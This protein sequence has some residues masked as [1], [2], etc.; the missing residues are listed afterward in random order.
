MGDRVFGAIGLVLSLFYIWQATLIEFS[1]ISDP[2]GPRTFPIIICALMALASIAIILVPD[3]DPHWP[4]LNG[5][6]EIGTAVVVLFVYATLLPTLGFIIATA[7][8]AYYITWRLGSTAVQSGLIGI[9]ISIGI[10]VV[11]HLILGL[12]L[13]KGPFGF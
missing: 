2:V 5:L 12:S 3:T 9:L 13:A 11:F 1:F 4:P 6:V 7:L 8:A 10:Y